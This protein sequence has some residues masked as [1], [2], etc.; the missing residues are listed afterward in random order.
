M[1]FD[2]DKASELLGRTPP[3][4]AALLGG[5]SDE[6][7][8]SH[9]DTEAW[10]PYD[11]I[12][13]LIHAEKTDWLPRARVI[14]AQ[15]GNVTFEPFD[16]LAQF[17]SSAGKSLEELL[18]EFARLRAEGL[19][20]LRSWNLTPEQLSLKGT[21]P[22]LGEVTLRELLATWVVHDLTHIRQIVTAMADRYRDD[23]GV[24]RQYLSIL[25][26]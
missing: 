11:V 17:G 26:R 12:G 16:R 7:T 14:L 22:E 3:T 19:E 13:H 23:V 21:H 9:G 5:L 15:E 1:N 8:R 24:W 10:Q 20:T 2:L 18:N 25:N 4:L 6:W